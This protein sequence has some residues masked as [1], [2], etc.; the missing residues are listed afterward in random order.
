MGCSGYQFVQIVGRMA[1]QI[2]QG[3]AFRCGEVERD[4]FQTPEDSFR[5]AF[6]KMGAHIRT[7]DM[8][9]DHMHDPGVGLQFPCQVNGANDVFRI[10][11]A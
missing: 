6:R 1:F 10:T 2:F 3:Q 8:V 4:L 11:A 7:G 9:R 5:F